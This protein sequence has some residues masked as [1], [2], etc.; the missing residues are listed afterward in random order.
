MRQNGE[1]NKMA[2]KL[3]FFQY[4]FVIVTIILF[5]CS[6]TYFFTYNGI[7]DAKTSVITWQIAFILVKMRINK[8]A[9]NFT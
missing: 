6:S 3:T 8:I 5:I 7:L 9:A 2:A 4:K 1:K